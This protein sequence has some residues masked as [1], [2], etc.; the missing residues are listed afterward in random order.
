MNAELEPI[1]D[2]YKTLVKQLDDIFDRVRDQHPG[3]VQCKLECSDCCHAL[4]DLSLVEALYI[5]RQFLE[6]EAMEEKPKILEKANQADRRIYQL[7]R[8]AFKALDAQEKTED[9]ILLEMAAERVRCPLLNDKN[10]CEIYDDRPITCRL[11]GI[12]TAIAGRGHTCGLS[13]FKEGESYP[14]VNLD[15]IHAKLHEW[16]QEVVTLLHSKHVKMGELLMPL[17]M[18]LLTV[19]DDSYLGIA[20]EKRNSEET[21]E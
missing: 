10:R 2:K 12:P 7:K 1:F 5:N 14:T 20:R 15:S 21:K 11:Y 6:K 8:K 4:F 16:S 13:A 3:C 17:S 19:F 9:L 18:A